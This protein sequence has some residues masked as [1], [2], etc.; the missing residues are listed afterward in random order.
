MISGTVKIGDIELPWTG[1]EIAH[2]RRVVTVSVPGVPGQLVEDLGRG[3]Y[4]ATLAVTLCG[5]GWE[6]RLND[7]L[8]ALDNAPEADV[9]VADGRFFHAVLTGVSE[10]WRLA[11]GVE[12]RLDV[13]EDSQVDSI[14]AA[15]PEAEPESALRPWPAAASAAAELRELLAD[16]GPT[17]LG[18]LVAAY[19]ALVTALEAAAAEADAS[20]AD[21]AETARIIV[22]AQATALWSLP[23]E[24][25]YELAL[26]AGRTVLP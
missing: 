3:G 8:F 4:R 16:T 5:D 6:E 12:L 19:G 7:V 1:V 18:E 13:V 24:A 21:G 17:T 14:L 2:E 25:R 11:D 9:R 22:S 26:A 20:T 23:V 15:E 10:R